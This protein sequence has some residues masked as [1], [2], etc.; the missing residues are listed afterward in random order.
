MTM[1]AIAVT[2]LA[3]LLF[4]LGHPNQGWRQRSHA[5]LRYGGLL[6]W[7]AG[8]WCWWQAMQP[9]AA[10]LGWL[11]LSMLCLGGWPWL[12]L[13]PVSAGFRVAAARRSRGDQKESV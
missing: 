7:I 2:A 12:S 8:L 1:V 10:V 4:Y 6:I 13:L 9:V 11:V 5:G 3:C